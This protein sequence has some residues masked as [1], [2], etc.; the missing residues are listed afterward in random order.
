[1]KIDSLSVSSFDANNQAIRRK[2]RLAIAKVARVSPHKVIVDGT[3]DSSGLLVNASVLTPTVAKAPR[4]MKALSNKMLV[5]A[6]LTMYGVA[7]TSQVMEAIIVPAPRPP[8]LLD[9][10]EMRPKTST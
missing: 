10:C 1:M 3:A 6:A 2:F 8:K 4:A 5:D 7:T 9:F